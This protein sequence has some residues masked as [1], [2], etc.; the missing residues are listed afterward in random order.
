MSDEVPEG[1]T[2]VWIEY[3]DGT[4]YE[5][6][7]VLFLGYDEHGVAMFEVLPPRGSDERIR[8]AG[9]AY[10][11]GMTSLTLPGVRGEMH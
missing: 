2:G 11:P 1:P 10:W 5:N 6:L 3:P 8:S 9:A 4:R 7:P